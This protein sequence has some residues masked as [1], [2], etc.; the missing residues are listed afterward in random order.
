MDTKDLIAGAI[1]AYQQSMCHSL[2]IRSLWQ[3]NKIAHKWKVTFGVYVI[4]ETTFWRF[5]DIAKQ[6]YE[7]GNSNSIVGARILTRAAIETIATLVYINTKMEEVVSGKILFDDFCESINKVYMGS[8]T[9]RKLPETINVL[10]MVCIMEKKHKGILQIFKDLC[11][12]AHPSF[13]GLTDGYTR[14]NTKEYITSFGNYWLDKYGHQH[15]TALLLCMQ[16]FEL[17]YNDTWIKN[18]EALENWLVDNDLALKKD[19]QKKG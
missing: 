3:R 6:A 4:R 18:F 16:I 5:V 15:E 9:D 11:E 19:R 14:I 7:M 17:E 2:D 12:T 10:T 8:R 13:I 1:Q